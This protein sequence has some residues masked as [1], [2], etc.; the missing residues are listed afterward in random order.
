MRT[1]LTVVEKTARRAIVALGASLGDRAGTLK[2]A[3]ERLGPA[4][5]GPV[6]ASSII[7][8]PA[9]TLPDDPA[10]DYPPYLNA[11]AIVETELEPVMILERLQAI[12]AELGRDRR[13]EGGRWRPRPIDLDLV[14]VDDLTHADDFL[15]LPHPRVA[16]RDFVL[17]PLVELWPAWRHPLLGRSAAELLAALPHEVARC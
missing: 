9:Q 10:S 6:T 14:A 5:G 1:A 4:L 13:K 2:V 8:T 15:T 17:R 3:L 11:V 7:E 12:E 16:E